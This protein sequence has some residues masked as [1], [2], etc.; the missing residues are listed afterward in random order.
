MCLF[1]TMSICFTI[2]S[3]FVKYIYIVEEKKLK[4]NINNGLMSIADRYPERTS[5]FDTTCMHSPV[6]FLSSD[7]VYARPS[8]L[9]NHRKSITKRDEG[10]SF[11]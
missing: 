11:T 8:K 7:I 9:I 2:R 1:N 4:K 3:I 10:V 5:S 6:H